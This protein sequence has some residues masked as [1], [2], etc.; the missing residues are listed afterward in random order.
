MNSNLERENLP[1][2][3]SI[4][5][6]KVPQ[7]VYDDETN[8]GF[9]CLSP[10]VSK[11]I[12]LQSSLLQRSST[13]TSF[14][15]THNKRLNW[16]RLAKEELTTAGENDDFPDLHSTHEDRGW[17]VAAKNAQKIAFEA[18]RTLQGTSV[19]LIRELF[20]RALSLDFGA[21]RPIFC[22][23]ISDLKF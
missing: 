19:A 6:S 18:H 10:L 1:T 17:F 3:S 5:E 8:K 7:R 12:L 2:F 14:F 4:D 22:T 9:S 21:V 16:K 13:S 15:F 20:P 23:S 11:L